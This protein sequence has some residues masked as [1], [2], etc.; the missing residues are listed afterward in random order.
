MCLLGAK[1][2][3]NIVKISANTYTQEVAKKGNFV[4]LHKFTYIYMYIGVYVSVIIYARDNF[5]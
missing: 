1:K 3:K 5:Y 4:V 2:A